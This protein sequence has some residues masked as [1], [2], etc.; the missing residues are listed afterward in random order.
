MDMTLEMRQ[1]SLDLSKALIFTGRIDLQKTALSG[2]DARRKI[3]K[4]GKLWKAMDNFCLLFE[5][6]FEFF[7]LFEL[8]L[9]LPCL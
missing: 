2:W 4:I 8:T 5:F 7:G 1:E 3:E 9:N 6:F